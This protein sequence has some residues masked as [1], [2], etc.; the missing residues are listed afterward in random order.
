MIEVA[1]SLALTFGPPGA[2]W[3]LDVHPHV[4]FAVPYTVRAP[5]QAEG[6]C[7]MALPHVAVVADV[8]GCDRAEVVAHEVGHLRQWGAL[9]PGVALAGA[10]T[11]G[12]AV[13]D[14]LGPP[15]S[16]WWP[17]EGEAPRCPLVRTGTAGTRLLPCWQP[18][19]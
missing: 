5:W 12:H 17:P 1:L 19:G 10:L 11:L 9:G 4:V 13:E 18:G 3:T 2:G 7:G 14:Y 15:G 16:T 6:R 8:P